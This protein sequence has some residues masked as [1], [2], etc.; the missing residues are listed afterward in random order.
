M[1]VQEE[2]AIK[3]YY[4]KDGITI[5]HGDCRAI[6]P[7]LGKADLIL[8]DIPYGEVNRDSGGL[9]NLD[10]GVADVETF[11]LEWA[12]GESSRL[13]ETS[14]IWCGT[15]QVSVLREVF[16]GQGK[17]TRVGV[18]EK[19]NPSPMNGQFMWLSSIE[20]C[21][22]ARSSKAYFNEF[23]QSPIWRGPTEAKQVH[24]TQKPL[25]LFRRLIRA[26]CKPEGS[27]I[28][29]TMGSGTTLV[30]AKLEGRKAIGI[31][32]EERYCEIAANRLK[33]GVLF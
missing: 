20:L 22:F 26:S 7:T 25:W 5:F 24:P 13:G 31:E 12:A 27:V 23:C 18:W 32:V 30:A 29:F 15:E 28:D 3:P 14:Y 6:L 10:K 9:R 1:A 17:T 2:V 8:A 11:P 19:T 4:D 33:Q 21:V 16:V